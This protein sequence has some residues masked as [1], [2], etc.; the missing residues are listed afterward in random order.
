MSRR[1]WSPQSQPHRAIADPT[2]P[3]AAADLAE[4]AL[5]NDAGEASVLL[6]AVRVCCCVPAQPISRGR[7]DTRRVWMR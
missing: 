1:N 4:A 2:A 6:A 3:D 5:K 7:V